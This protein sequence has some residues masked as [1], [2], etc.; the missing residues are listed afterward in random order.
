MRKISKE[1]LTSQKIEMMSSNFLTW[2]YGFSFFVPLKMG[3]WDNTWSRM[4]TW[5]WFG[6][7]IK[8]DGVLNLGGFRNSLIVLWS[9]IDGCAHGFYHSFCMSLKDY[10]VKS[11]VRLGFLVPMKW[12]LIRR[13]LALETRQKSWSLL[14]CK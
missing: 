2:E 11:L 12:A 7:S 1:V 3:N 4:V 10:P 8:H 6:G 5:S 14:P 13:R 9:C